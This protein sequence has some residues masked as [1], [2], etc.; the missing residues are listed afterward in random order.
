MVQ[1]NFLVH[2]L[3]DMVSG[4]KISTVDVI[5][6]TSSIGS[7]KITIKKIP[8]PSN[9]RC[10]F[11]FFYFQQG[12]LCNIRIIMGHV[13]PHVLESTHVIT[14]FNWLLCQ[15]SHMIKV[16]QWSSIQRMCSSI[17]VHPITSWIYASM[18]LPGFMPKKAGRLS[19]QCPLMHH[20]AT[21]MLAI[22]NSYDI[23][24]CRGKRNTRNWSKLEHW[25]VAPGRSRSQ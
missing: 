19:H 17:Y 22:Y 6:N 3:F 9:G 1:G 23:D 15:Q 14:I 13:P 4:L 12:N 8:P 16:C 5:R 21:S 2:L 10:K 18:S 25:P 11:T 7:E 20:S 24:K